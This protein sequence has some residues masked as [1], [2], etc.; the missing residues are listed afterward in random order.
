MLK[1]THVG[2]DRVR[3][4]HA[5][6]TAQREVIVQDE[7]FFRIVEALDVLTRFGVISA[8]VDVL[9]HMKVRRDLLEAARFVT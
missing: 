2:A 6:Q 1:L 9:H 8:S 4:A 3:G 7:H 5:A